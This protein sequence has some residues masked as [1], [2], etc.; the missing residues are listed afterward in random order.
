MSVRKWTKETI[1]GE[2]NS[3]NNQ[4]VHIS[5]T[6]ITKINSALFH[7][8]KKHFGSWRDAVESSGIDYEEV[9]SISK[10]KTTNSL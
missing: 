9:L 2:I 4:G 7:A 6:N 1:T 3:L 8:A 10:I 5:Q